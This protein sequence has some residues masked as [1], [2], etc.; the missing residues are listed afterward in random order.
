[1]GTTAVVG[2][3]QGTAEGKE[4]INQLTYSKVDY[5]PEVEEKS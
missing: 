1:M 3:A 2:L 4:E 5:I